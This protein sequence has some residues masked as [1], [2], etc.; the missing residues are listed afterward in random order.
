MPNMKESKIRVKA[1]CLFVRDGRV[2]LQS[3]KSINS[4][5]PSRHV[6]PD[7]WYRVLGGSLNFLE[8]SEQGVR[9]EIR[10]EIGSEIDNLKLLDA[11]ENIF[12]YKGETKHE[13][14][15][16]YGGDLSNAELYS[17][18][19]IHVVDS[20]YEFDAEWVSVEKVLS[21][22]IDLKPMADYQKYLR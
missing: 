7:N 15:F 20:D 10:E 16:L 12:E 21:G 17:K 9:R 5:N 11:V 19:V 6:F 22:E 14:V 2:L 18:E 13:V 3:G 1:M 8:T 4:L